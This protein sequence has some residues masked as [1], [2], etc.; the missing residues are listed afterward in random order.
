MGGRDISEEVGTVD[1]NASE[2]F[3]Q[4]FLGFVRETTELTGRRRKEVEGRLVALGADAVRAAR[5][6]EIPPGVAK[7]VRRFAETKHRHCSLCG[8]SLVFATEDTLL[9]LPPEERKLVYAAGHVWPQSYSGDSDEDNL[10]P[11][12]SSCNRA[13]DNYPTWAM[14]D[15]QS[16]SLG[17]NPRREVLDRLSGTHR[18]AMLS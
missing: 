17:I 4:Q 13:K 9:Q 12:C 8:R 16:I 1:Q 15:V 10:L 5:N 11:A 7:A 18:F 6:S 14:V 3:E 2:E